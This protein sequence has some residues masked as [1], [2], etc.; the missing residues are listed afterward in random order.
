M[1]ASR[2][3]KIVVVLLIALLVPVVL[4]LWDHAPRVPTVS[5]QEVENASH[6]L[7]VLK[8]ALLIVGLLAGPG[9]LVASSRKKEDRGREPCFADHDHEDRDREA[10]GR[11]LAI[12]NNVLDV[13]DLASSLRA[14]R[15]KP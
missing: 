5:K 3:D 10:V 13:A 2:F 15:A 11:A 7:G 4:V 12:A 9:V 14:R 6:L 8:F 1:Q